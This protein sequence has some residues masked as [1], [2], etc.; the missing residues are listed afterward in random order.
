MRARAPSATAALR[1]VT[2][3]ANTGRPL[4]APIEVGTLGSGSDY[5]VF[6]DHL[7]I[8]SLD[9]EFSKGD[10]PYGVY[11]SIYDS[12][13]WVEAYG[14]AADEPGSAFDAMAAAARVLGVLALRLADAGLAPFGARRAG[15]RARRLPQR[16]PRV[17]R[18]RPRAR[19]ARGRDRGDAR[20]ADA[21]AR[22][23]ARTDPRDE[24]AALD[25]L[26]RRL[27]LTER[28]FRSGRPAAAPVVRVT[29]SRRPACTSATL[30]SPSRAR[31]RAGARRR[32]RHARAGAGRPR[33]RAGRGRRA[34]R[35]RSA[36]RLL[37]ARVYAVGCDAAE[38]E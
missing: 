16:A 12:Y 32:Q 33:R 1:A 31:A 3:D 19:A 5:A 9:F 35:G 4:G 13:S 37:G 30:R 36:A 23:I 38:A 26:N 15:G 11:H 18:D 27:T 25:A 10:A 34:T 21:L 14:G 6:L 28:R 17:Q 7:G 29:R 22:D 20:A 24:P 8:A 2:R